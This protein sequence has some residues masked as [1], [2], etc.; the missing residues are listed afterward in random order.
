MVYNHILNS[1]QAPWRSAEEKIK[2][3]SQTIEG[4]R[5][6]I[7]EIKEKLNPTTPPK[8]REKREQQSALHIVDIAK[9]AREVIELFDKIV[10]IWT[11]LEEAEK[12]QQLDQQE[13]KISASIKELK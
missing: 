13:D 4:Y 1:A 2:I 12:V 9:E 8:I 7:E 11:I 10:H 6:K 5:Q 3:I